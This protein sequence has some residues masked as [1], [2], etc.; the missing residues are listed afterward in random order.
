MFIDK[1]NTFSSEQAVTAAAASTDHIDLGAA[2]D[3]GVGKQLYVAVTCTESV[4]S[5]GSSTVNFKLQS[6]SSPAFGSAV[7]IAQ[8][9]AIAKASLVAGYQFFIPIPPMTPKRYLRM[10]YDVA[11]ADLTAGKFS[12]Q[13][14]EGIQKSV[15]YPD[16]I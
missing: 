3:I 7:D 12:A 10:Y 15:A 13:V 8:S 5:G 11:T 16:A 4:T 6:D 14:V 9:G 1:Q 2:R